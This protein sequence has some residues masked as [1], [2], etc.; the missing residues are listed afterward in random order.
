MTINTPTRWLFCLAFLFLIAVIAHA[1]TAN[2]ITPEATTN[3]A[4]V[5]DFDEALKQ[6]INKAVVDPVPAVPTP[7]E[8]ETTPAEEETTTTDAAVVETPAPAPAEEEEDYMASTDLR[9]HHHGR[10][11]GGWKGGDKNS[12]MGGGGHHMGRMGGKKMGPHHMGRNGSSK[13]GK[14]TSDGWTPHH[15]DDDEDYTDTEVGG[16]IVF[17]MCL[18]VIPASIIFCCIRRR[19]KKAQAKV[20][21]ERD[22]YAATLDALGHVGISITPI[23]PEHGVVGVQKYILTIPDGVKAPAP[24]P[25]PAPVAAPAY[26]QP[27]P[28]PQQ[29]AI[30]VSPVGAQHSIN[31][32]APPAA[33]H[34]PQYHAGANPYGGYQQV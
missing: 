28:Q 26:L 4:P 13:M 3:P 20:M 15:G 27:Q 25:A 11:H 10:H 7:A 29:H 18:L 12:M 24:A 34:P 5:M 33:Y 32:N 19:D 2:L 16:F 8:E 9:M 21:A 22:Q 23:P 6:E 1:E 14:G 30:P 17:G 31:G